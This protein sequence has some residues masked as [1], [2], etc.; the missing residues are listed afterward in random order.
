[1]ENKDKKIEQSISDKRTKVEIVMKWNIGDSSS[2]VITKK[3]GEIINIGIKSF[4]RY[5]WSSI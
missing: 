4:I 1:M 3:R 2:N 5:G